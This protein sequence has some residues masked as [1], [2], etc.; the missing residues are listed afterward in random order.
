MALEPGTRLGPYEIAA[1][2]GVGGMGEVYRARDTKLNR[3]VAIKVLPGS[4]AGNAE[5]LARFEREA[6]LLAALN[7]PNIAAIHGLV[8]DG[9]AL[10]GETRPAGH[11]LVMEFVEGPTLQEMI[12]TLP[13][14]DALAVARQIAGALEAAHERGIIHRDLKPANIKV[15]ADGQVKVL[16][17][18]LAKA[19]EGSGDVSGG[20]GFSPPGSGPAEAGPSTRFAAL[21]TMTSPAMTEAGVILGTAAYMSPEQARGKPVDK[22]ADIWAFGVVLYEMLTGRQAFGGETISDVLAAVLTREIDWSL[23]PPGTPPAVRRVLGRCLERDPKK[24]LRDIGDARYELD[25]PAS[26]TSTPTP[27]TALPAT[28]TTRMPALLAG[29]ALAAAALTWVALTLVG[30][31]APAAGPMIFPVLAPP[32]TRLEQVVVSPDGGS[33][34]I[35]AESEDSVSHLWVRRLDSR[36]VR[37]LDGTDGARD[38]FWSPDSRFI[39]YFTESELSKIEVRTGV[40]ERLA[41]VTNTRGGAWNREGT[42]VFGGE[43]LLRVPA[44]GGGVTIALALDAAAGENAIRFPGFLPDGM[45]VLFYSRNAKDRDLAGLWIL[46]LETGVRKQLTAAASSSAVYVEPGV[47]LYRR[48]RYL[49]AHPFDVDRLELTGDPTPLAEDVWY[50]PGVTALV[51]V[52]ASDTG[53]VLFRTGGPETSDLAWFD[54]SG[55]RIGNVWEPKSFVTVGLSPDGRQVL[56]GFPDQGPE[57]HVWLYDIP[58][59]TARQITSSGDD[60]GNTVFSDDGT[61]AVLGIAE[62]K[63]GMWLARLGSGAAPELIAADGYGH[64]SDWHGGQVIQESFVTGSDTSVSLRLVDLLSGDERVLVD[65]PANE[66]FGTVSPDGRWLAYTSDE[67]GQ[68][69]VYVQAFPEAA[70]RWKVSADGGHQPRWNPRGGELFYLAPD[71]RMMSVGVRSG[72]SVFQW[73]TPRPLFKTDIVDL[74][75]YRGSWGYAVAPDGDRFLMLT[76]RPQGPSPALAIINWR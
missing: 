73:D 51:N 67:S 48:D 60:A 45:H 56:T 57:R 30:R 25:A 22:R 16:D 10:P 50:E 68:W 66:T 54:R 29:T 47:L 76:R 15:T 59:A 12:G 7:H 41:A 37:Q 8:G 33:L 52:S 6:Q 39:G 58:S 11:A 65:T 24:R 64:A 32:D 21:P 55:Q 26:E 49:I 62:A 4:V 27:E 20:A 17:F 75:P 74:G 70:G 13:L 72:G 3:D 40:A 35:V 34:A 71:R 1:L 5:R 14:E 31:T 63:M 36:D 69:D 28:G 19:M 18:G 2:V 42:I 53:T 44:S 46:S 23:L 9:S 43:S 61:Q 38:P